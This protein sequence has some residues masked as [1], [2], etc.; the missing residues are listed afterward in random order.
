MIERE[1][2]ICRI[3]KPVSE[4]RFSNK[5]VGTYRT[6]CRACAADLARTARSKLSPE[7]RTRRNK[8]Y[9]M[10]ESQARAEAKRGQRRKEDPAYREREII[11]RTA[12]YNGI[13]VEDAAIR[14]AAFLERKRQAEERKQKTSDNLVHR[15]TLKYRH[16]DTYRELHRAKQG[17][18][19]HGI[20]PIE[21]E[22]R[23]AKPCEICGEFKLEPGKSGSGMHIDHDHKTNSLRGTLC[24]KCNRGLGSFD[25]S[26]D[27]LRAAAKY[28][29]RYSQNN[30]KA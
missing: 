3:S 30:D 25:D 9:R 18:R 7:E 2:R 10:E 27:R 17:G 15:D 5:R 19:K 22:L 20:S 8:V 26:V 14:R 21:Y 4:F 13:S 24:A 23:R 16:D 6:E 28:L 1:C 12:R 29:K 11:A